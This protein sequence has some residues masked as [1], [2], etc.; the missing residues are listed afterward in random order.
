M[1]ST[2]V[3]TMV[4]LHTN[5]KLLAALIQSYN[6]AQKFYSESYDPQLH[7]FWMSYQG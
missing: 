7:L 3:L 4:N 6:R 5:L 1:M 2:L